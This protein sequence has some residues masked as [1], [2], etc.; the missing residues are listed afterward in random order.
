MNDNKIKIL[1]VDDDS[2]IREMYAVK[3][4]QDDELDVEFADGAES[5]IKMLKEGLKPDAIVFDLIMPAMDGFSMVEQIKKENLAQGAVFVALT[6][7]GE[8]SDYSRAKEL[9]ID[10][11]IV[12]ANHI[13]SE[14]VALIKNS[15]KKSKDN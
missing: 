8:K 14:V 11:Y 4:S 2:F 9:G 3:F 7:Q 10:Q 6:N 12:K 15:L 13:P 5:A 1:F